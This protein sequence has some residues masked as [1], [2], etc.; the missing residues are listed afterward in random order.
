MKLLLVIDH[1]GLGGAQ[2]QFAELACGLQK[3]RHSVEVFNYFPHHDFFRARLEASGIAI[4][5]YRKGEGFSF[6]VLWRLAMLAKRGAFDAVVSYL[7]SPNVYNELAGL[8]AAGPRLIVS[9][10]C[11]HHDESSALVGNARRLLHMLS[12]HVVTNSQT[13]AEWLRGKWWLKEKTSCIYNGV[14]L[15]SLQ[16][17]DLVP[18]ERGGLRLLAVGRI[19]P[20]K[21]LLNLITGLDLFYRRNGY[22]PAVSWAGKQDAGADGQSYARRVGELLAST[23]AIRERWSWLGEQEDMPRLLR[24][25]HALIHPSLYEGL[26]NSVCEALAAGKPVLVSDVGDHPLLVADGQRGFLFDPLDPESIAVAVERLMMLSREGWIRCSRNAR[27]Y[28]EANLDVAG[29]VGAYEDLFVKLVERRD[30]GVNRTRE[31]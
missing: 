6:G 13:H 17:L 21:N 29:M 28:A 16:P 3:R 24:E 8:I 22:A 7:N 27:Q 2:R 23:P 12:D 25:H 15:S 11:S 31:I 10:R 5:D 19:C 1:L 26:P 4:H 14:D 18:Q 20:Q 30:A 9:E